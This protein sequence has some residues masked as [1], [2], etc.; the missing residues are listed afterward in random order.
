MDFDLEISVESLSPLAMEEEKK[1]FFEVLSVFTQFPMIGLNPYLT[2]EAFNRIGYRN[3]K[4]KAHFQQMAM[5]QMVG[6]LN[7]AM[8]GGQGIAQQ[9]NMKNTPDTNEQINNQLNNQVGRIQ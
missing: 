1:K 7:M 3:E 9:N 8:G 4:V 5:L 2:A 6:A